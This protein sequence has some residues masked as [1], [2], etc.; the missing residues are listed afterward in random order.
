MIGNDTKIINNNMDRET[1]EKSEYKCII[2]SSGILV[3]SYWT[4]IKEESEEKK[5]DGDEPISYFTIFHKYLIPLTLF[6]LF[7]PP[8]PLLF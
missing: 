2:Y 7:S 1:A 3:P 5:L 6:F 8:F 4:I